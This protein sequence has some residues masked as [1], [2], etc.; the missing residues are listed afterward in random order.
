MKRESEYQRELRKRIE[1]RFPGC[2]IL[3]NDPNL[4][5]GILDLVI[6]Y[7]DRY[8]FLEVKRS[9]DEPYQPNQVY[10]LEL[11]ADMSFAATIYPENEDEVLDAIQRTFLSRGSSR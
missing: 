5:Q 7:K 9:A 3:K 11:F 2:V 8:A 1:K 10:Y 6:F 4:L